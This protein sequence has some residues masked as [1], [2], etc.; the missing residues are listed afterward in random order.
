MTLA[1]NAIMMTIVP[2][3]RRCLEEV[4]KRYSH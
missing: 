2:D 1:S 4:G 3:H